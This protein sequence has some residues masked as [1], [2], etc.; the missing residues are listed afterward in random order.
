MKA[1][2]KEITSKS[3][4]LICWKV[5]SVGYNAVADNFI[6]GSIFIRWAVFASQIY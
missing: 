2:R 6:H 4:H 3:T 1:P 5:H